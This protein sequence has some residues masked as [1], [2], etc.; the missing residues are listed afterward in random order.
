MCILGAAQMIRREF[1]IGLARVFGCLICVILALAVLSEFLAA[2]V[3]IPDR[4][5]DLWAE[6]RVTVGMTE[7]DLLQRLG[8][9]D[10]RVP[11]DQSKRDYRWLHTELSYTEREPEIRVYLHEQGM[12][13][14]VLFDRADSAR[15]FGWQRKRR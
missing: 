8:L 10:E 14:C 4:Q 9:P 3:Q 6:K 2:W 12:V 11:A 15:W 1:L 13:A 7:A 5:A